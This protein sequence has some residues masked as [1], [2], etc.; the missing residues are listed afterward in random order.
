RMGRAEGASPVNMDMII[1]N[2]RDVDR[3]L[4]MGECID[5]MERVLGDLSRGACVLPLRNIMW[6]ADK[7]AALGMMPAFWRTAGVI[8]L[9]A[10]TYFPGNEGTDL[11]SHQGAV[12]LYDAKCG[13]LIAVVD[14]TSITSIRTAA[15]S[16]VATRRLA[17]EDATTLA[18]I[19]AGVQARRH[20]AAMLA[21]RPIR[22]VRVASLSVDHARAFATEQRE[23]HSIDIEA[24]PTVQAAIE[25]A[26]IICTT[27]SSSEPVLQGEWLTP[28]VHVNA[29]GSSVRF[30]RELDAAAVKRARLYVDRRESALNEAGDFVLAKQEGVVSDDHI[31]AE[32]G[33]VLVGDAPGRGSPEEI[34]LFKSVGLAVEDL[35]AAYHV[36]EKA[37]VSG[38][39]TRVELGG[40]R[41]GR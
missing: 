27:T 41:E 21:V 39:G 11:D 33:E 5:V 9:K 10:V 36:Y 25:G 37:R 28:G 29:V 1:L 13:P 32:I 8:G 18:I 22:R 30:A 6:L 17:R 3:L 40:R 20:L 16:G 15:V 38:E 31:V 14:G 23:R 2:H 12:L 34:T 7:T 35:A 19:G 26:D 24:T 4:P